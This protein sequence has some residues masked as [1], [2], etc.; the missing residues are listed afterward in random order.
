MF[1]GIVWI[2]ADALKLPFPDN[3]FDVYTVVFGVRN[4]A[5]YQQVSQYSILVYDDDSTYVH[6]YAR[7]ID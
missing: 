2:H 4:M 6:S 1:P 7:I 3:F 5:N